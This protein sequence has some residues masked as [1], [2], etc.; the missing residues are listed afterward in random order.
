MQAAEN[1]SAFCGVQ[2]AAVLVNSNDH[3]YE[4]TP[5]E[6]Q[7]T[8]LR[9]WI[10]QFCSL[11]WWKKRSRRRRRRE[12]REQLSCTLQHLKRPALSLIRNAL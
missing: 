8:V 2:W 7:C 6:E 12:E 11:R 5:S 4:L 1:K 9:P 3:L 10:D